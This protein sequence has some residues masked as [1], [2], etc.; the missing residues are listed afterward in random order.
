MIRRTVLGLVLAAAVLGAGALPAAADD[1]PPTTPS[2]FTPPPLPNPSTMP[3]PGPTYV[4][5]PGVGGSELPPPSDQHAVDEAKKAERAAQTKHPTTTTTTSQGHQAKPSGT[6]PGRGP[7]TEVAG[8][9]TPITSIAGPT[10]SVGVLWR[11]LAF[12]VAVVVMFEITEVQ[13]YVFRRRTVTA[14]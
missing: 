4:I 7:V 14:A 5:T 1:P 12:L 3:S 11:V 13:R 2:G 6:Q 8:P 10:A 9:Q